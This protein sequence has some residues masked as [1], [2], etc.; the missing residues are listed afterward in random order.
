MSTQD[1]KNSNTIAY[2]KEVRLKIEKMH[3]LV[4][5]EVLNVANGAMDYGRKFNPEA[6]DLLKIMAEFAS[7]LTVALME[8]RA[9]KKVLT[10]EEQSDFD[11]VKSV[12]DTIGNLQYELNKLIQKT[13][14]FQSMAIE[15]HQSG[16][17]FAEK[18]MNVQDVFRMVRANI[19]DY[20]FMSADP[21]KAYEYRDQLEK[22]NKANN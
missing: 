20:A 19:N 2:D 6:K 3:D 7:E 8:A 17:S 21:K 10:H 13:E 22:E 16:L 11:G 5:D 1:F 15:V 9:D 4:C 14:A 18:L 12:V